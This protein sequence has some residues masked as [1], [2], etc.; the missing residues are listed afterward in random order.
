MRSPDTHRTAAVASG[1]GTVSDHLR[2]NGVTT[3]DAANAVTAW[4][5]I[6]LHQCVSAGQ[7]HIAARGVTRR[8]TASEEYYLYVEDGA[9]AAS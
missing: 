6:D 2:D 8:R 3:P 1:F 5:P 7:R 9:P 4:Q